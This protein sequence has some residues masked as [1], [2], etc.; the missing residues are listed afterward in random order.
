MT[1]PPPSPNPALSADIRLLGGMLGEILTM[2][3]G[4]DKLALVEEIR[5]AARARR[6]GDDQAEEKMAARIEGL[7]LE[8]RRVLIKAFSNYFQLINIA[9]DQQRIRVLRDR[10]SQSAL[11]ESIQAALHTLHQ[12]GISAERVRQI[13]SN[14]RVRLV[15]TAHPSEAKRKEVLLKLRQLAQYMSRRDR[16]DLLERER[17]AID[18]ALK[19]EIEELWQTRPTRA[20]RAT[21]A[22]EVDFGIYFL[23]EV[24]MNMAFD[25]YEELRFHLR[26]FYPEMDWT[27]LP[28]LLRFASWIGGDRDGNPN[29]TP[30]VTME[31]LSTQWRAVRHVYLQEILFLRDHLTQYTEEVGIAQEIKTALANK[32][33]LEN[34][35]PGELYRQYLTLIHDRLATDGYPSTQ[36][37]MADLLAI[38]QSLMANGGGLA[39]TVDVRRLIDKVDLFGLHLAALDVREDARLFSSALAEIFRLYGLA[40]DY[41]GMP[42][43]EK[44]ALLTVEIASLRPLFPVDPQFSAPTNQII[45]M[46]RM[47]LRAF[48]TYGRDVIDTVIGSMTTSPSDVLGMLLMASK[49]GVAA[50]VDI[51]PLFETVEDLENAPGIIGTLLE[52]PVYREYLAKRG[53]R[54]QVM[55]G[56]SDSN[57]DGGYLASNWG[58]YTAQEALAAV[59]AKHNIELELFH[60]RGG[61]IGRGGGPTNQAILSAPPD[62]MMG[63]VKITEQGEV[64]AYRYSNPQ[65][66]RRHLNQVI[67]AVLL[68]AA[69]NLLPQAE[70]LPSW[71]QT[72]D[73]LAKTGQK[74]YRAFVY[75]T[76]GFLEYW[77]QAT[78]IDELSNLAIS[79]RPAKRRAGGF[80]GLRAIPWVFS[81]MQCRAIIPSW[82]GVGYALESFCQTKPDGLALL[83][84]MTQKW[85]FFSALMR[86]VELDL[87]KA[88]M[89]IAAL[90]STLV[91]DEALRAR[92]FG[93]IRD[94]HK[95]ACDFF[96][97]VTQQESL[98]ANVPVMKRSIERRNPYVDPLN[99]IQVSLLRMLRTLPAD[100][101]ERPALMEAVLSTVNGIAAGMKTTG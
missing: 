72:M 87:A 97:A 17:A 18:Q 46:W 88:D 34:K 36:D 3:H 27:R 61:S 58:L 12:Q 76:P 57:K 60:G 84:E 2:Q 25:I 35:Y 86:N 41:Q 20:A 48:R 8:A 96:C 59:C 10:E 98:L 6:Q 95:R 11:S 33:E 80:E 62:S 32:P 101:P 45:A 63:K 16:F 75:E 24:L 37:F 68:G 47:I 44:Q 73:F 89:G 71:R 94:E 21:V 64:I 5:A 7:D 70:V 67:N 100:A 83:Q 31:T 56:Y 50:D 54:Q 43:E 65:I 30:D 14:I 13:L 90:Y 74:A 42:E 81:W 69:S 29:V 79:S 78:P 9:E 82:Y 77:Q 51:V 52:N 92:I 99:F 1:V 4:P 53:N 38:E 85:L 19:G 28:P 26:R 39:A 15:L 91:K 93:M 23:T 55:I 40:E 49:A 22:D 66:A